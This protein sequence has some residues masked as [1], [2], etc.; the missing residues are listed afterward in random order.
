MGRVTRVDLAAVGSGSGR[1]LGVVTIGARLVSQQAVQGQQAAVDQVFPVQ[2]KVEKHRIA[3][4]GGIAIGRTQKNPHFEV[5]VA[6]GVV[7]LVEV[8]VVLENTRQQE[9][10]AGIAVGG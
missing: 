10:Q 2:E 7:G 4:I 1:C 5:A 8:V 3:R 6:V 9:V